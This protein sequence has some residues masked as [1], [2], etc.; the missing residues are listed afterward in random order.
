MKS[1]LARFTSFKSF[2]ARVGE[3]ESFS[4]SVQDRVTYAAFLR[5]ISHTSPVPVSMTLYEEIFTHQI[6]TPVN[7]LSKLR[8]AFS[9]NLEKL[10]C[11]RMTVLNVTDLYSN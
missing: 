3:F 11:C 10:I 6:L 8:F 4:V 7:H 1:K 5:V 2:R 9:N